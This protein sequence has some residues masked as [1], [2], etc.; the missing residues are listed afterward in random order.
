MDEFDWIKEVD[1]PPY[2]QTTKGEYVTVGTK[3]VSSV[4][5]K[6]AYEITKIVSDHDCVYWKMLGKVIRFGDGD[7]SRLI[8]QIDEGEFIVCTE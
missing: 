4:G 1:I 7:I 3:I 8:E 2:F 5:H 6:Y